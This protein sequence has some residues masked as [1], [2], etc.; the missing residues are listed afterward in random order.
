MGID[1][2]DECSELECKIL[3]IKAMVKELDD[4]E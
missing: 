2:K 4:E 3:E 1:F